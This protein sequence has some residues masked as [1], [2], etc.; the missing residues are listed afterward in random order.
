MN[1]NLQN[2]CNPKFSCPECFCNN[3]IKSF[4]KP[5]K[6]DEKCLDEHF[7]D[8][9]KSSHL[10]CK[11]CIKTLKFS[12]KNHYLGYC[13]DIRDIKLPRKLECYQTDEEYRHDVERHREQVGR[14]TIRWYERFNQD[15]KEQDEARDRDKTR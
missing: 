2:C 6:D 4:G 7:K 1:L 12:C 5:Y 10:Y 11:K 3:C 15:T 8:K 13:E 14:C 9:W